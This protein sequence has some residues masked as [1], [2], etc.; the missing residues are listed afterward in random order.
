MGIA[1]KFMGLGSDQPCQE[2]IFMAQIITSAYLQLQPTF[3]VNCLR[4][5]TCH[6]VEFD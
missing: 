5:L 6:S 4:Y 1:K 3:T 2:V